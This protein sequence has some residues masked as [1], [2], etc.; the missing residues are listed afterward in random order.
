MV[1]P[2]TTILLK[3]AHGARGFSCKIKSPAARDNGGTNPN[4][5]QE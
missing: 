4:L 3:E 5:G 1:Q 2:T